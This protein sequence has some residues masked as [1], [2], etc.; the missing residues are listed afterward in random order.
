M[1]DKVAVRNYGLTAASGIALGV[2]GTLLATKYI[3][4]WEG[5]KARRQAEIQAEVLAERLGL[6]YVKATDAG[7]GQKI[8]PTGY[9]ILTQIQDSVSGLRTDMDKMKT[10]LDE[11][12]KY[13]VD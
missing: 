10:R 12:E 2:L 3:P 8:N 6:Q 13:K 1:V 5:E 9:K 7:N 11:I 4:K